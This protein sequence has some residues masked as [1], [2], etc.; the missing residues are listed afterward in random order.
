MSFLDHAMAVI[1]YRYDN[2]IKIMQCSLSICRFVKSR[3]KHYSEIEAV[4][5]VRLGSILGSKGYYYIDL[6][7]ILKQVCQ[8]CRFLINIHTTYLEIKFKNY[9]HINI[10]YHPQKQIRLILGRANPNR[11][12]LHNILSQIL[13]NKWDRLEPKAFFQIS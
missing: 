12:E 10:Y 3:L 2:N 5:S 8:N 6:L 9:Y 7:K 4:N 13:S 11:Y 1:I